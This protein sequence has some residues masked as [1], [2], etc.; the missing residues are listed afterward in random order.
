MS[1]FT[2]VVKNLYV[3]GIYSYTQYNI[4]NKFFTVVG[5]LHNKS[6]AECNISP[7]TVL[8]DLIES[9]FERSKHLQVLLEYPPSKLLSDVKYNS[10]NIIA[11]R[12]MALE[13]K[14][15]EKIDG[16]DVRRQYIRSDILYTDSAYDIS[17]ARFFQLFW[18]P[19]VK[20]MD[21]LFSFE[22]SMFDERNREYLQIYGSSKKDN[23]KWFSQNIIPHLKNNWDQLFEETNFVIEKDL[24]ILD[25]FRKIWADASDFYILCKVLE[26]N[27]SEF[28][29]LMGE[30][31]AKNFYDIFEKNAKFRSVFNKQTLCVNIRNAWLPIS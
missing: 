31:H 5:E 28:L 25:F 18:E 10:A 7:S 8:E 23:I 26:K 16:F 29:I 24:T 22:P 12:E 14:K 17:L 21:H 27:N 20:N 1:H 13:T 9:G 6:R 30:S 19:L 11:I 2:K 15:E 4:N 3:K